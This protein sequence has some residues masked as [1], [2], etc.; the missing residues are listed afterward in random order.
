MERDWDGTRSVIAKDVH[1]RVLL[2]HA[3]IRGECTGGITKGEAEII[4][5]SYPL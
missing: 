2:A 5:L 4:L 1:E 3:I